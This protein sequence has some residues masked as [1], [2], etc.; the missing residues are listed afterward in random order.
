MSLSVDGAAGSRV[1]SAG[2]RG[3]GRERRW[4]W[5]RPEGG[6]GWDESLRQLEE[7]VGGLARELEAEA[8]NLKRPV[9]LVRRIGARMVQLDAEIVDTYS[10]YV[11][12][13]LES[14]CSAFS[15][16]SVD[17][18]LAA[19]S[20]FRG[21]SEWWRSFVDYLAALGLRRGC[22]REALMPLVEQIKERLQPGG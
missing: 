17:P 9:L 18:L 21:D 2:D 16:P 22:P 7:A 5:L 1:A 20:G 13:Q 15:P 14:I 8:K 12:L 10:R 19:M 3:G 11:A 4:L 6:D